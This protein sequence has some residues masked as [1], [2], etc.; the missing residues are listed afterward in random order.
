MPKKKRQ[1]TPAS[2]LRSQA[3]ARFNLN[4]KSMDPRQFRDAITKA[5]GGIRGVPTNATQWNRWDK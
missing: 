3:V 1:I 4:E 2:D 5:T